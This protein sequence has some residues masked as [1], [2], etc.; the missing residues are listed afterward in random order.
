MDLVGSV[1]EL[2]RE[3]GEE[4]RDEKSWPMGKSE[5]RVTSRTLCALRPVEHSHQSVYG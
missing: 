2:G 3:A 5:I 4:R 1:A